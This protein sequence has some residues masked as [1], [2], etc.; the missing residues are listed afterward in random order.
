M[1]ALDKAQN[2]FRRKDT[3]TTKAGAKYD[4]IWTERRV[5]NTR[6][7]IEKA[8]REC[9]WCMPWFS[10]DQKLQLVETIFEFT[11][12]CINLSMLD[13][14]TFS[15]KHRLLLEQRK[16]RRADVLEAETILALNSLVTAMSPEDIAARHK[17]FFWSVRLLVSCIHAHSILKV[18]TELKHT[19]RSFYHA[20]FHKHCKKRIFRQ[21]CI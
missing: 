4:D 10:V 20:R 19:L 14:R 21:S 7:T 13:A 9:D 12:H 11:P 17:V 2:N 16:R 18:A 15:R 5:A 8:Y 1:E 6:C 3:S